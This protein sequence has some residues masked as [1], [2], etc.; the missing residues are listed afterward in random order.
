MSAASAPFPPLPS[1]RSAASRLEETKA[2]QRSLNPTSRLQQEVIQFR[3]ILAVTYPFFLIAAVLQRAAPGRAGTKPGLAV[4]RRS[5]FAEA[6][7]MA[8]QAI[9]F[10]FMG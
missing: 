7:A 5:V 6:K 8:V 2:M 10:A 4:R 3:I 9:P 1:K